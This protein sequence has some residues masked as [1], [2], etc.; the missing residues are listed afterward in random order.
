MKM[1]L[2]N[3][4]RKIAPMMDAVTASMMIMRFVNM[5]CSGQK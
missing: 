4:N 1:L 2:T 5:E 3:R